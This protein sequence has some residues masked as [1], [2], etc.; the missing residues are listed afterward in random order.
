[1]K[2]FIITYLEIMLE[3]KSEATVRGHKSSLNTFANFVNVEEPIE[4]LVKD[5]VKFRNE[6]YK[7]KKVGT[8][9]TMLK[10]VKL[11][12]EWCEQNKLV[13]VSPAKEVK[14]LTEAEAL[15]K[16]LDEKQEDLLVRS[17]RSMYL[18]KSTLKK[19]YR[20]L[21]IVSLMLKAGLRVGEVTGLK[22][23]EIQLINGKGK[24]LVRGKG[25]Q[26]RTVNIIPELAELILQYKEHHGVK[27]EHVLYSQMSDSI[28]ERMI[29]TLLKEFEGVSSKGVVISEIHPHLLRHTFAHNLATSGVALESIARV[30]GHMKKS[31]EP[32]IA[33]TIRYTKASED[34]IG[35]E[36]ERALQ[37]R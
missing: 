24:M 35:D 7:E 11:F 4:V 15:P 21:L 31:G 32:N 36:M 34:E 22:W 28:S 3:T 26:Q 5:V 16:W 12:L 19:S 2:S 17:V 33:M 20:E 9:N 13:D 1:M 8:V 30:L 23:D 27:G 25:Q 18:G 29:Q 14:L 10:R 6:L 37:T